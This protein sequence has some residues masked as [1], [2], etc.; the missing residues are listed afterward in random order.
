M[1][2]PETLYTEKYAAIKG[3]AVLR[4]MKLVGV[5]MPEVVLD[6]GT[7][8]PDILFKFILISYG[9]MDVKKLAFLP[10]ADEAAALIRYDS[11]TVAIETLSGGL[12]CVLYPELIPLLCR[13]GNAK[14]IKAMTADYRNWSGAKGNKAKQIFVN[15]LA[16]SS[17]REAVIWLEKNADLKLYASVRG[18]TVDEVY[19][20]MLFD[21]GFDE[22]GVRRFDLGNT[23]LEVTL[24]KELKLSFFDT[25]KQKVVKSVPKTGADPELYKL[26]RDET[27]DMRANLKKAY[28]IKKWKL[29]DD[30]L[31]ATAQP[32]EEWSG[33][34][35]KKPFLRAIA[36]LIVWEQEGTTFTLSNSGLIRPDGNGYELGSGEIRLAHPMEMKKEDVA[37]WQH[38][39]TSHG[40]KQPFEQVWEPVKDPAAIRLDRYTGIAIPTFYFKHADH[41]GISCEWYTG[42]WAENHYLRIEGFNTDAQQT[43]EEDKLE[44]RSIVHTGEWD[45]RANMVYSYLDR[46]TVYGR[47]KKDDITVMDLMPGFTLAQITEFIKAAQ[48]AHA[49]NVTAALLEYKNNTFQDFDPMAE[50]TLDEL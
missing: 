12:N 11:L 2:D 27:E 4:K 26:A 41:R 37:A 32:A 17:T 28:T 18:I 39:F 7:K 19:D 13:F 9:G 29:F 23:V 43:A 49:A 42:T 15:A 22:N 10:E 45:R 16:L 30:Y 24:T 46:I 48:E 25:D 35:M 6:D 20:D 21:F 33:N 1:N 50:F 34:N 44:I 47:V 5:R 38:Y 3:G 8:A 31:A 14:Q 36:E 40:L